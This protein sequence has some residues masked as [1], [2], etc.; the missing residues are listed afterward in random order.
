MTRLVPFRVLDSYKNDPRHL[1]LW[2]T[3]KDMVRDPLDVFRWLHTNDV[4]QELA[5]F[6]EGW[7]GC[8]ESKGRLVR[9]L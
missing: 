5:G 7:A 1:R 3:Y 8:L 6:Y 9:G 4:L 2:L